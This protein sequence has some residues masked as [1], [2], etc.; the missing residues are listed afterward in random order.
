[1][2]LSRLGSQ[3]R[4][5]QHEKPKI[6]KNISFLLFLLV[7]VSSTIHPWY[8][9]LILPFMIF[10][11]STPLITLTFTTYLFL[12]PMYY[13]NYQEGIWQELP[14]SIWAIWVPFFS[15][16][17]HRLLFQNPIR[18]NE[19]K[20]KPVKSISLIVP[21]YNEELERLITRKLIEEKNHK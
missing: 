20:Y 14:W 12:L 10:N 16:V 4:N 5:Q 2:P 17:I 8:L 6:E 19:V 1:M 9:C 7:L 18:I 3:L 13:R 11:P 15:L 21:L